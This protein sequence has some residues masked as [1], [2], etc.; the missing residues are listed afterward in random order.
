M[1][2]F[3]LY[4]IAPLLGKLSWTACRVKKCQFVLCFSC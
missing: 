4:F 1:R 2:Y 3:T